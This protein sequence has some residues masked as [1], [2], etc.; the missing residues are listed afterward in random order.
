MHPREQVLPPFFPLPYD[1]D[2]ALR[3]W[4]NLLQHL[5]RNLFCSLWSGIVIEGQL[6][7]HVYLRALTTDS[8]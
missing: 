4:I 6:V 3:E 5:A 8:S 1:M 7:E 2:M